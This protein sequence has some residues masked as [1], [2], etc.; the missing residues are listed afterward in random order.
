M[1]R[2]GTTTAGNIR[3]CLID[4]KCQEGGRAELLRPTTESIHQQLPH[5]K[6]DW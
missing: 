3:V 6:G 2:F 1:I 5:F 4:S